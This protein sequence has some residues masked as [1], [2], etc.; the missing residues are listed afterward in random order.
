M[1]RGMADGASDV[2]DWLFSSIGVSNLVE[3]SRAL[4]VKKVPVKGKIRC[5]GEACEK[6]RWAWLGNPADRYGVV[7]VIS[8]ALASWLCLFCEGS[9]W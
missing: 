5:E 9:L 3:Y 6:S 2:S 7:S 4:V 8:F 1:D